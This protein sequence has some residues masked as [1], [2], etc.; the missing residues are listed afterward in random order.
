MAAHERRWDLPRCSFRL[1]FFPVVITD[2]SLQLPVQLWIIDHGPVWFYTWWLIR[3]LT[4]HIK[5]RWQLYGPYTAS[6]EDIVP[7][8]NT[9]RSVSIT[10]LLRLRSWIESSPLGG[11]GSEKSLARLRAERCVCM[12]VPVHGVCCV[13]CACM[14]VCVWINVL[15][16]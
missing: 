10:H 1:S 12:C 2:T 6:S 8:Y 15:P 14:R 16:N 11:A 7:R 9:S 5:A 4:L 13:F 3:G